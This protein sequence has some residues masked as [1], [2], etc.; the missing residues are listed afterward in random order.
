MK[1]FRTI[2]KEYSSE[3]LK[4]IIENFPDA[5]HPDF[6]DHAKDELIKRGMK[7]KSNVIHEYE[8][9]LSDISDTELQTIIEKRCDDYYLEY[10]EIARAEYLRRGFKYTS[11]LEN[12]ESKDFDILPTIKTIRIILWVMGWITIMRS[13]YLCLL[14]KETAM[15][16]NIIILG[17]IISIL[18]FSLSGIIKLLMNIRDE[19]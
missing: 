9:E 12:G 17:F 3:K 16:G 5:Y 6:I 4:E 1:K 7:F 11:S 14:K 19:L 15:A 18:L 10:L 13:L 2:A 8:K